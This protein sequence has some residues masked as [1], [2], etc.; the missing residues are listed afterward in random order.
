MISR[1][2]LFCIHRVGRLFRPKS[3]LGGKL[4]A[5]RK[6]AIQAG[7][8]LLS[9]DEVLEEVKARRGGGG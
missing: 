6:K 7:I 5:I 9:S 2:M 8:K 1:M 4:V 3:R